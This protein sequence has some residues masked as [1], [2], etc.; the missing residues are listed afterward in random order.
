MRSSL[1]LAVVATFAVACS[2]DPTASPTD[3]GTGTDAATIDGAASDAAVD[4]GPPVIPDPVPLACTKNVGSGSGDLAITQAAN[5]LVDGDVLCI[6]AGTYSGFSIKDIVAGS[7]KTITI[8]NDGV[9]NVTGSTFGVNMANLTNVVVTG[10]GNGWTKTSGGIVFHD[11]SYR[12]IQL[13]APL[14]GLTFQ[15]IDF[16]NIG[17]YTFFFDSKQTF[18]GTDATLLTDIHLLNLRGAHLKATFVNFLS[19]SPLIGLAKNVELARCTVADAP[20]FAS[21]NGVFDMDVHHNVV[22]DINLGANVHAG[23]VFLQGD[24]KMHHNFISHV[25]GNGLRAWPSSLDAKGKLDIYDNVFRDSVKYSAIEIQPNCPSGNYSPGTN[26]HFLVTDVAIFGNTAG[27]M[28][29]CAAPNPAPLPAGP[30]CWIGALV[31][32][33]Q[34]NGGLLTVTD[35][36]VFDVNGAQTQN[37]NTFLNVEGTLGGKAVLKNNLSY[38]TA[39]AAGLIDDTACKPSATS[40]VVGAGIA[41]PGLVDD[42]AG[43]PRTT[44]PDVGALQH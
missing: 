38:G 3:A 20:G 40:P 1:S 24:G 15:H 43:N 13:A 19:G 23:I 9:V 16:T 33:Y 8:Q 25:L 26:P 2:S 7:G 14:H 30:E 6:K 29:M 44:P 27:H 10:G 31:D 28:N 11:L 22:K 39:T 34:D 37:G 21:F 12:A 36:L 4:S 35:N 5:G 42:Y 18:D 17:D 32:V 41:L